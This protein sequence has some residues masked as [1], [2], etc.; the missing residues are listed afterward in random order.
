MGKVGS[1]TRSGDRRCSARFPFRRS[2]CDTL[3]MT[4]I[5]PVSCLACVIPHTDQS[6]C[7][8]TTMTVRLPMTGQNVV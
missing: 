6:R 8:K 2:V 5:M 7:V 4:H 1:Q 3:Q